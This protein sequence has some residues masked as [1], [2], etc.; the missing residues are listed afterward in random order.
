MT[1]LK[2]LKQKM[3]TQKFWYRVLDYVVLAMFV[4]GWVG[5][6]LGMPVGITMI[7]WSAPAGYAA[8]G[9]IADIIKDSNGTE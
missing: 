9:I 6:L 5:L 3:K 8:G 1:K 4:I 2:E 7:F